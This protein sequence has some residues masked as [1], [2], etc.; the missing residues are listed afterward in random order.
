MCIYLFNFSMYLRPHYSLNHSDGD[1]HAHTYMRNSYIKQQDFLE[2]W[3][4]YAK[5]L[6]EV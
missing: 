6:V 5:E 4:E 1:M 2:T 3:T